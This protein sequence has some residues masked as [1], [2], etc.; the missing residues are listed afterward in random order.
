MAPGTLQNLFFSNGPGNQ[1]RWSWQSV[2]DHQ[3]EGS[4]SA[5][6][7][8]TKLFIMFAVFLRCLFSFW[9]RCFPREAPGI[10]VFSA[11]SGAEI[12]GDSGAERREFGGVLLQGNFAGFP[13]VGTT[14]D[15]AK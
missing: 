9:G 15:S 14:A 12:R 13:H 11:R 5:W 7:K 2:A 1:S 6:Q 8:S 10:M 3:D 4:C